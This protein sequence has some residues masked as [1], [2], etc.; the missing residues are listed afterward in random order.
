MQKLSNND[1]KS[2]ISSNRTTYNR[3]IKYQHKELYTCIDEEYIG[4][5]FSEKLYRYLYKDVT[6][7][8]K[9]SSCNSNCKFLGIF[10]GFSNHCSYKCSNSS[11]E[12]KSKKC[13]SYLNNYG[14]NNPSK[15]DMI[16][17][18]KKK[19]CYEHFGV[20]CNL[21]LELTKEK[22]K[23]TN[24][25]KYGVEY[26]TQNESVFLKVK[27]TNLEKYGMEFVSQ[28]EQFKEQL[29][30]T[31]NK[32]YGV[33]YP[34]QQKE[35]HKKLENTNLRKYGV[36]H[37]AQS[38]IYRKNVWSKFYEILISSD[39]LKYEMIPM[40][41]LNDY[42][43]IEEKYQFKCLKCNNIFEDHLQDGRIPRC[44]N[45][46]PNMFISHGEIEI[47][48]FIK[49]LD[50]N[51]IIESNRRDL[52]SGQEL[53]IFLPTLKIAIE[54]DGLFWHS[55]LGGKKHKNY[56]LDKTIECEKI[57]IR[58]IHIFED[59][60]RNKEDIVKNR[61]KHI[62]GFN[63][64]EK[65]YARKCKVKEISYNECLTFLEK[66]HL[67]GKSN[68][69]INIGLFYNNELVSIM[70]FGSL[71]KSMGSKH[72]DDEYE[73]YR[74]CSSKN[75]IGASG[76]LLAYFVKTY[77]PKKIISY[78]DRRWSQGNVYNKIG[79]KQ[80]DTTKPSYFY[81]N[82][83]LTKYY[84]FNFR[85]D[86]LSKKLKT[87]SPNL[88]EWKNMQLNGYDRIWDCGCLKYEWTSC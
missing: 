16:K 31:C 4:K 21:S 44:Y 85:K 39:R 84:R 63:T 37:F 73:M 72:I 6:D 22:I 32:K 70:T 34:L 48:E 67:Q 1:L 88:T 57:G 47:T 61:L 33:P 55:E 43:G 56:H 12:T 66:Y 68:S 53:D 35:I 27:N 13:Q 65:I 40:F 42:K 8:G 3:I 86:R 78:A 23:Q 7:L 64:Q 71:R 24:L 74:F 15:S 79:F 41:S 76:K 77:S 58:L 80:I 5:S 9:C 14:V 38:E 51:L 29:R 17:E 11:E 10:R 49:L 82:D 30:E 25:I 60:W 28:H 2:I 26:P 87:F 59:E 81:M 18:K 83:Y 75:V 20:D 19:T 69:S 36:K 50:K 46:Y 54:Y 62:L 45:C 52:L